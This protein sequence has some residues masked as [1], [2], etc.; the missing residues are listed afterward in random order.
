MLSAISSYFYPPKVPFDRSQVDQ[1]LAGIKLQARDCLSETSFST[2]EDLAKGL[3]PLTEEELQRY[4]EIYQKEPEF[5]KK[6]LT[7]E[8]AVFFKTQDLLRIRKELKYYVDV[9]L[10]SSR[11]IS[12]SIF[13]KPKIEIQPLLLLNPEDLPEEL[14]V[15]GCDDPRL[16]DKEY[17]ERFKDWIHENFPVKSTDLGLIASRLPFYAELWKKPELLPGA[18]DFI[19]AHEVGHIHEKTAP[20]L[21]QS[22]FALCV[23][24]CVALAVWGYG[25]ALLA[26]PAA[27]AAFVASLIIPEF[28]TL[29]HLGPQEKAPDLIAHRLVKS[30]EGAEHFYKTIDKVNKMRYE[31]LNCLQATALFLV[32]PATF[33][34]ISRPMAADR[35][36]HLKEAGGSDI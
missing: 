29:H 36:A 26:I 5:N 17:L 25:S 22:F 18:R 10:N 28:L 8:Y 6:G 27:L 31:Q 35:I 19:I 32:S 12:R 14:I 3:V 2:G 4:K 30:I 16:K 7:G 15:N 34:H 24:C 9:E 21:W 33:F 20:V 11:A 13:H 23:S 1:R